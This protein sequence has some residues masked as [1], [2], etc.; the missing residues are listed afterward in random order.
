[1]PSES[2]QTG[3]IIQPQ[4]LNS[5]QELLSDYSDNILLQASQSTLYVPATA[6][7]PSQLVIEGLMKTNPFETAIELSGSAGTYHIYAYSEKSSATWGMAATPTQLSAPYTRKLGS[8][9][10]DGTD[11]TSAES[12]LREINVSHLLGHQPSETSG[13]QSIPAGRADGTLDVSWFNN[14]D[15]NSIPVGGVRKVWIPPS[16]TFSLPVGWR[17]LDGSTVPVASHSFPGVGTISLPDMR[18]NMA[19]GANP[20][21]AYNTSGNSSGAPAGINGRGGNVTTVDTTHNHGMLQSHSHVVSA[22]RHSMTHR[23]FFEKHQHTFTGQYKKWASS[24]SPIDRSYLVERDADAGFVTE[25]D[26]RIGGDFNTQG[27]RSGMGDAVNVMSNDYTGD[28]G[29]SSTTTSTIT[30]GG[31][32]SSADAG[33]FSVRPLTVGMAFV[34]RVM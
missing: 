23:H 26:V 34:M 9:T 8:V 13:S 19:L 31:G 21:V 24:G 14:L 2:W 3:S 29:S 1:M 17:V 15:A 22:H 28:T 11:I 7:A 27:S 32:T 4:Y 12:E 20:A 10:F 30:A 16:V 18:N 33:D 6:S 5:L 25:Y